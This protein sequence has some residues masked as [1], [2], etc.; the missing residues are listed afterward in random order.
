[1]HARV[2]AVVEVDGQVEVAFV[3]G[4]AAVFGHQA[5]LD[6]RVALLQ[7]RQA[8]GQPFGQ[9]RRNRAQAQGAADFASVQAAQLG[10]D[11]AIG[12][13]DGL[14]Q[15]LAF[16]GQL[17]AAGAAQEQAKA[18]ALFQLADLLADRARGDVQ[19]FGA[20]GERQMPRR[21][22][23][24]MQPDV[25]LA[26]HLSLHCLVLLKACLE[27]FVGQHGSDR[28]VSRN[29]ATSIN[30]LTVPLRDMD[31]CLGQALAWLSVFST[32]SRLASGPP[33]PIP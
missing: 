24:H 29:F 22:G 30:F 21:T 10:I 2:A 8:R 16:G 14:R 27:S 15:A 25:H 6:I 12:F 26:I 33:V 11:A 18:Q 3:Q 1:M 5:Q 20:A 32:F 28:A 17:H 7:A 9:K 31:C 13:A 23:K 19:F 4:L